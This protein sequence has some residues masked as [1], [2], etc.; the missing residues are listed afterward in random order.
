MRIS[1]FLLS[2]TMCV[3]SPFA[4]AATFPVTTLADAGAGSLRN[5]IDQANAT[6]TSD[7]IVFQGGLSGTISLLSGELVITQDIVINGPGADR[8]TI[9]AQGLGRAFRLD[10]PNGEMRNWSI[11]GLSVTGGLA[12]QSGS[13]SG[14]G[15]YYETPSFSSTRPQLALSN[16]A[17]AGNEAARNGGAVSVSGANLTL[18]D[19]TLLDNEVRNGFQPT[20]GGLY[21]NRGLVRIERCWIG[22]NTAGLTGGGI[23][24]TSPGL[25]AVI[26]DSLIQ[27]NQAPLSGA[28][29]NAG[30]MLSLKIS[31]SAFI[32][33]TLTS[34]PQ[35]AG[36]Y[37]AGSTDPGSAE[38]IIENT[39]FSG[40]VAVNQAGR[41]SALA[42]AQGNMTVRNSTIAYN[43]TA[44]DVAPDGSGGGALWVANGNTTRVIVQSTLFVGNTH[45]NTQLRS[46]L[47]RLSGGSPGSELVV[48]YSAFPGFPAQGIITAFGSGNLEVD[49]QLQ[50]LS[51]SQGG[52]TPVHALGKRSPVIDMGSNPG[53]LATDQRGT[54][55]ARGWSNPNNRNGVV[56]IGAYE[57]RGDGLLFGDFE[58]Q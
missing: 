36:I 33:N 46:D 38:N 9:D 43:R 10:N 48:E 37:F 1:D 6:P 3:T 22:G 25:S 41:G 23:S 7:T 34:Q 19:T 26:T 21:F 32:D 29:M 24:L 42:V 39:T 12:N 17:F 5:A 45:G 11:S 16:M 54:G 31:R 47:T 52:L 14:G 55:F 27:G 30:T 15:L 58:Q 44:P 18:S 2:A 50:P 8:I 28:G 51:F 4:V 53:N 57:L 35:G 49:A 20:G 13:D 40:N 56:D